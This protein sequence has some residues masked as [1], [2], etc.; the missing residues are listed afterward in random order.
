M[1]HQNEQ[2]PESR[3]AHLPVSFFSTVMGMTGLAIAWQKAHVA[4][5]APEVVWQTIAGFSSLLFAALLVAYLLKMAR[6]S[7]QVAAEWKH[8]VRVNFF[9]TISI[10]LL[11]LGIVWLETAPSLSFALWAVGTLVH[12]AFTFAILSSWM[13]HTH[14]DIKHANPGWFIPVVGNLFVPICGVHFV[15]PEISWFFFSIGMIFWIVLMTI[16]LYRIIFHDPIPPRLLPTLFILLAPPAVGFIAYGALSPEV[17]AFARVLYYTALFLTFLLGGSVMRFVEGGFFLSSW[18]YSFPLAAMTIATFVM[19]KRS[20]LD[21][22]LGLAV[23]LLGI[24]SLVVVVLL[25]KTLNAAG[26]RAIC[27]PE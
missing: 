13:H 11:L 7:R 17:D 21:Y 25:R 4:L 23:V 18:A 2:H 14:Y 5:G 20:G 6:F 9:P 15:S 16:V 1:N 26:R 8:P 10:S 19:A 24:V 27:V 12:L 3:L 22:F